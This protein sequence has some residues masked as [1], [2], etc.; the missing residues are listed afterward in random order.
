MDGE[1]GQNKILLLMKWAMDH[2]KTQ[3]MK[4]LSVYFQ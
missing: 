1:A 4:D 2:N 3:K